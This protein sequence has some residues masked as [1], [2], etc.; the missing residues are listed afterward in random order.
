MDEMKKYNLDLFKILLILISILFIWFINFLTSFL[1]LFMFILIAEIIF[2]ILFVYL[3]IKKNDSKYLNYAILFSLVL[4]GLVNIY[5][6]MVQKNF[7]N[8]LFTSE[9]ISGG[10]GIVSWIIITITLFFTVI[11]SLILLAKKPNK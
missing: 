4:I 8:I 5:Y 10:S 11:N 1:S 2:F 3:F 9:D 6:A 7:I